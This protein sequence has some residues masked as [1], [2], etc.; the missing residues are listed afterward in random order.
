MVSILG[1]L[2]MEYTAQMTQ[3]PTNQANVKLE[4]PIGLDGMEFIEY[5]TPEPEKLEQLFSQL[6]FKKIGTHKHKKVSLHAQGGIRFILNSETDSFAQKFSHAHG[7]SVCATGFRVKNA[8]AAFT[9]AVARGAKPCPASK[10]HSFPAI[11]GI[12]D[13]VIYF[14]DQY[15]SPSPYKVF[16]EDFHLYTRE[17]VPGHD[18]LVID[19]LTNNV[20]KGDMQIW[21]DFYEKIFN[22][23][24]VRYFDIKGKASGLYSKVMRSP[25][26]K[27][28]IPI[29][30]P[31]G[32]KSQIQEYLDEYKGSGIQH[33]ALLSTDIIQTVR[34]L[35]KAGIE[36]LDV[37]D[38]Y[39][40]L[41]PKRLPNVTEDVDQLREL[42]ILA[43]GDEEG[44]LLQI[45]SKTV[46]GPIFYEIIQRMNHSGFGEGNFQALF[47]SIEEDQRR[48]GY[49]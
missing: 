45:F 19:H 31:T 6:G 15:T 8:E 3:G 14:I 41:L 16:E 9:A 5:A 24:E 25:C 34:E 33:I 1:G 2:K 44:Y 37:I 29:N 17:V 32:Q 20:P 40:D 21:C 10:H 47:D 48:R 22:F 27:I 4:N 18:L 30:E 42:K 11:Y 43:D 38:T 35:K 23:R 49:L 28:I 12:G 26:N 7:P 36:F 39:Y 46:I 13:S